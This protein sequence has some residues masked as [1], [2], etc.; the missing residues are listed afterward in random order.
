MS[1]TAINFF[2]DIARGVGSGFAA[3]SLDKP[4]QGMGAAIA[5]SMSRTDRQEDVDQAEAMK[6][7]WYSRQREDVLSDTAGE[8]AYQQTQVESE[9][10]YETTQAQSKLED[11]IKLLGKRLEMEREASRQEREDLRKERGN[12]NALPIDN[13]LFDAFGR[14]AP[15][16][17]QQWRPPM[18]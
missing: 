2:K 13:L 11:A 10:E 8:R 9:R 4:L 17:G 14:S 1:P 18:S 6:E 15:T 12:F 3:S 5:G 7:K 16:M